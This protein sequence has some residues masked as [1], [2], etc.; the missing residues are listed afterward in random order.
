MDR[1]KDVKWQSRINDVKWQ[2]RIKD[3][4]WYPYAPLTLFV[5]TY[6]RVLVY[7]LDR[8]LDKPDF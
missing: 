7:K 3:V 2:S 4:K 1:M 8:D 6:D 5:L